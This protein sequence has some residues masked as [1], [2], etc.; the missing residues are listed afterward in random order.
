MK[1]KKKNFAKHHKKVAETSFWEN[2][3][4]NVG[5]ITFTRDIQMIA[6]EKKK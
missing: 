2:Y 5:C 3:L 4:M 1:K 6:S